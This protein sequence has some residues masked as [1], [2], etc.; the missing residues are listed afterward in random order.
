MYLAT[1]SCF[2]NIIG[3]MHKS[4][5]VDDGELLSYPFRLPIM[6]VAGYARKIIHDGLTTFG[7][8]VKQGTFAHIWA[9]NDGDY[10]THTQ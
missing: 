10:T 2:E 6:A 1:N 5:G 9:A 7:K 8:A 3:A 4:A